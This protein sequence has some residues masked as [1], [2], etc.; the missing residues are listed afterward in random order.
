MN[1]RRSYGAASR[2]SCSLVAL[3]VAGCQRPESAQ[4]VSAATVA[5]SD[6]P[7]GRVL[8]RLGD[9]QLVVSRVVYRGPAGGDAAERV[10][11]A[12]RFSD[13]TTR[14]LDFGA[15]VLTATLW[16]GAVVAITPGESL[17]LVESDGRRSEIDR[18]VAGELAVSPDG[19][20]LAYARSTGNDGEL[21]VR[22][23]QGSEGAALPVRAQRVV[24][25]GFSSVGTLRFSEDGGSLCFVGARNGGVMGVHLAR[26]T[27]DESLRCVTNCT[28]R[29]GEDWQGAFVELPANAASF[30][31]SA[32]EV[33]WTTR[34][35]QHVAVALGGA[36]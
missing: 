36:S 30:R 13:G 5:Q 35:G 19:L 24:A 12:W 20:A 22:R 8:G 3:L 4:L 31:C 6:D 27:S 2:L 29:T 15:S 17:V 16:R 25:R 34:D 7:A 26:A 10:E 21:V 11:I 33:S 32:G 1:F 28:L 9:R 14:P 18:E 23:E